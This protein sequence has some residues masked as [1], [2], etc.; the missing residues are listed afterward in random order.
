MAI[1]SE[2]HIG[3]RLPAPRHRFVQSRL[4]SP[5]TYTFWELRGLRHEPKPASQ[6]IELKLSTTAHTLHAHS[7]R[8]N[9]CSQEATSTIRG[10]KKIRS[11]ASVGTITEST[12]LQ[13]TLQHYKI[14]YLKEKAKHLECESKRAKEA[15][16][17]RYRIF[18]QNATSR[19]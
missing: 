13:Q 4:Y 9:F 10:K 6:I 15:S 2:R 11:K 1:S 8:T 16:H 12:L 3:G 19:R 17:A 5:D 7:R 18:E 14:R